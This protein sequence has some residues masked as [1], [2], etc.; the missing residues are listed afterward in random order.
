L[1]DIPTWADDSAVLRPIKRADVVQNLKEEFAK[2][3]E[4][5][6]KHALRQAEKEALLRE[7]D[8]SD[9]E[10]ES[11]SDSTASISDNELTEKKRRLR[12][13]MFEKDPDPADLQKFKQDPLDFEPSEKINQKVT[14]WQG[15]SAY[16]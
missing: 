15:D 5:I 13:L 14:L 4:L 1:E 10:S 16:L 3:D 12:R 8:M 11:S 9:S 2:Y 7:L 6:D